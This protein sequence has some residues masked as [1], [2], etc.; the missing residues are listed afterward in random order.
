MPSNWCFRNPGVSECKVFFIWTHFWQFGK[1]T[2]H[3][4]RVWTCRFI[5]R[6]HRHFPQVL[7]IEKFK[8]HRIKVVRFLYCLSIDETRQLMLSI[9]QQ[10][11]LF[12][13]PA[14]TFVIWNRD[15]LGTLWFDSLGIHENDRWKRWKEVIKTH[16]HRWMLCHSS[17]SSF[18]YS[19]I[20]EIQP[21]IHSDRKRLSTFNVS[22]RKIRLKMG[23]YFFLYIIIAKRSK[24]FRLR[25]VLLCGFFV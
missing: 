12:K 23:Y 24:K 11:S 13:K 17:I 14:S 7:K 2:Q 4:K 18:S 1:R 16:P 25:F 9:S 21:G 8:C 6:F 22:I 20:I 3:N 5:D 19:W 15:A 10:V